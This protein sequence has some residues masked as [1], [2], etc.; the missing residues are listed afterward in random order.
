MIQLIS[1]HFLEK[2]SVQNVGHKMIFVAV[3]KEHLF[4]VNLLTVFQFEIIRHHSLELMTKV[5]TPYP[6]LKANSPSSPQQ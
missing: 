3:I 6:P 4:A 1:P 2:S 5:C